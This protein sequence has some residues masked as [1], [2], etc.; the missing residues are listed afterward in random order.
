MFVLKFSSLFSTAIFQVCR[1]F[2]QPHSLYFLEASRCFCRLSWKLLALF[3]GCLFA[4]FVSGLGSF[5]LFLLA[6]F[7]LL[8]AVLEAFRCYCPPSW[9]TLAVFVG[10]LGFS[11]FCSRLFSRSFSRPFLLFCNFFFC[12]Q[13]S[14]F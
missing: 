8:S 10:R 6:V 3:V 7:L 14:L 2:C 4:V 1:V 5:S 11:L 12:W 9:K 13:L